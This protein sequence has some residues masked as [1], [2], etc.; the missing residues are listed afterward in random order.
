MECLS[1]KAI[2][3]KSVF[4]IFRSFDKNLFLRFS[5]LSYWKE[6]FAKLSNYQENSML[7]GFLKP[8][9]VYFVTRDCFN[10]SN[11]QYYTFKS[12]KIVKYRCLC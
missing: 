6:I 8:V 7:K 5:W 4:F 11:D 9:H 12:E 1:F 10:C 3:I 2:F